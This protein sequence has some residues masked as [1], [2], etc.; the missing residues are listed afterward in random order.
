M[1]LPNAP[2]VYRDLTNFTLREMITETR[3]AEASIAFCKDV[4]Y[5][6]I[7]GTGMFPVGDTS[8]RTLIA[9]R[10]CDCDCVCVCVRVRACV[11]ACVRAGVRAC[12]RA[13]VYVLKPK[14][15]NGFS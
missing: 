7:Y 4:R 1:A 5:T 9:V 8:C 13:C 2:P 12:V 10:V 6:I 3:D 15:V 11:R 14:V